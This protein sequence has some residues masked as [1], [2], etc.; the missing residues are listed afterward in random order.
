[1]PDAEH[2]LDLGE[3][4]EVARNKRPTGRRTRTPFLPRSRAQ[5]PDRKLRLMKWEERDRLRRS[6]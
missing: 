6:R 2:E 4:P 5:T 3:I 1:M